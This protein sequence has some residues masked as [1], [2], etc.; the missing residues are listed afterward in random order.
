MKKQF[1]IVTV[2]VANLRKEPIEASPEYARDD[3]QETQLLYN[4]ILLCNEERGDWYHVE[5]IEQKKATPAG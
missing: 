3:L 4:E 5:A 2:P 1:L